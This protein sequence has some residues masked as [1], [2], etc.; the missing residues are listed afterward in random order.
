MRKRLDE[1]REIEHLL[2][3]ETQEDILA[4]EALSLLF[5]LEI[6]EELPGVGLISGALLNL[7]FIRRVEITARHVFQERWVADN[8]K[9]HIIKPAAVHARHLMHGWR[10]ALGRMAYSSCYSV[11]FGVTLPVYF[12]A[13]LGRSMEMSV[14]GVVDQAATM[15]GSSLSSP[16]GAASPALA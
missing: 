9:V 1:L 4:D 6:F 16:N 11:A 12:I 8:G 15:A 13:S 10:G 2:V 14:V 5:Q 7:I 3:E